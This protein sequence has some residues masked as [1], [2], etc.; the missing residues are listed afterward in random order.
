M[1]LIDKGILGDL[2]DNCRITYEEL[3]RKHGISANAVKKRV[4]KLEE[5]GVIHG[6]IIRLSLAMLDAQLLFGLL[7]TDGSQDEEAFVNRIGESPSIVAAAAYSDG[8]YALLAEYVNTI[9][10]MELGSHL[11]TLEGVSDVELH[12]LVAKR[13]TKF[14]LTTNHLKVLYYLRDN[15]RM[16]IVDLARKSGMTARRV[17]RLV[18][19]LVESESIIFTANLELGEAGSIPFLARVVWNERN[20]DYTGVIEWLMSR[21]PDSLWEWYVSVSEPAIF[22][23]FTA[24]DL[25]EMNSKA[26]EIR[27]QDFV[28]QVKVIVASYHDGFGGPRS[29]LLN[30][31]IQEVIK[32]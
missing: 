23:L 26:R 27:Q 5:S 7:Q 20:A 19:E 30:E 17:R 15:P 2:L 10:L 8:H 21:Y 12:T 22:C 32:D 1:D 24:E 29:R 31:M 14:E 18:T 13:G 9:E 11:R 3:S 4:Q 16:S 25:N 28:D 6:Y